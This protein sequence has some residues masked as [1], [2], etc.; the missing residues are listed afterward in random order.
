M[1]AILPGNKT[2][3]DIEKAEYRTVFFYY[4]ANIVLIQN[5]SRNFLNSET[6]S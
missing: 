3:S 5:R 6:E 2:A 1:E 4:C